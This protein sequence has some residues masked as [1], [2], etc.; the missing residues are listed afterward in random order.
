MIAD[1]LRS[2]SRAIAIHTAAL[3]VFIWVAF[4]LLW[5]LKSS[6]TPESEMLNVPPTLIPGHLN[7]KFYEGLFHNVAGIDPGTGIQLQVPR[8]LV[9]SLIIATC[10]AIINLL[11][12]TPAAYA[13]ARYPF[14]LRGVI[15]NGL[16]A[17]RMV[18]SLVLMVPF[19][20]LFRSVG[21][22]DSLQAVIVAHVAI[23]VP[24]SVW[25]MRGHFASVPVEI[26][27]AAR[28]DGCSRLVAFCRVAVAP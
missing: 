5:L 9:N 6:V 18:P 2:R 8:S 1:A 4:P 10:V 26:E 17:S 28:V 27:K 11:V 25:I 16:L 20:L 14:R 3:L 21:L 15:L 13:L 24:F 12:A 19:Y 22:I 23:S 7:L